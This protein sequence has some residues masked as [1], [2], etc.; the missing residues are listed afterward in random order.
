MRKEKEQLHLA[1]L[2]NEKPGYRLGRPKWERGFCDL[3]EPGPFPLLFPA[4][5]DMTTPGCRGMGSSH[6]PCTWR[7]SPSTLQACATKLVLRDITALAG[8]QF[9]SCPGHWQAS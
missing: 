1:A 2:F 3:F 7:I 9:S 8:I 5:N 4:E 6:L